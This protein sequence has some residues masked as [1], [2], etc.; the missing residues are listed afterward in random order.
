M[1]IRQSSISHGLCASF[2]VGLLNTAS[3]LYITA[4]GCFSPSAFHIRR[5][6]L[7]HQRAPCGGGMDHGW[8][9]PVEGNPPP[10][11][12]ARLPHRPPYV[13]AI[14]LGPLHSSLGFCGPAQCPD[15]PL[16]SLRDGL[17]PELMP[18]EL[19]SGGRSLVALREQLPFLLRERWVYM[20]STKRSDPCRALR[21]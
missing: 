12:E 14:G 11:E 4:G 6:V 3:L 19:L 5:T 17:Q 13:Q 20:C 16:L 9:P 18:S 8:R 1:R 21:R 15:S 7:A 2:Y 10:R